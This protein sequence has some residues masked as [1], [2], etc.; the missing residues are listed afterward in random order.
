MVPVSGAS[1]NRGHP[2]SMEEQRMREY[3]LLYIIPA[4]YTDEEI[5]TVEGT[6]KAILEK[7]GAAIL[8]ATR[9][10][11]F[12]LT[13]PIKHVRHGHYVLVRMT[14][15]SLAVAAIDEALRISP[16]VLRHLLLKADEAGGE[17][18]ELVQFAE[19]D[20]GA[21][22]DRPRRRREEDRTERKKVMTDIKSGV[23]A[24]EGGLK[25]EEGATAET[26]PK[27]ISDE[28]LEKKIESALKDEE[29]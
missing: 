21:K 5:G 17:K 4:T 6:V 14:A 23:A 19:V 26:A 25:K 16:E 28:E 27:E 7:N 3:E 10:G 1:P 18:F 22:D 13:Y 29:K 20:V 2:M 9:L 15:A 8:T 24:L 11:K 12:R